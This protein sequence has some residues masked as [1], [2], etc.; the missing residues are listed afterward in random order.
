MD[1]L[2]Q[3]RVNTILQDSKGLMWFGTNGGLN[4]Y[5]GYDF[6]IFEHIAYDSTS[7]S[8]N[9]LKSIL[10]DSNGYIWI[11]TNVGLNRFD[12]YTEKFKTYF[13]DSN[14]GTRLSKITEMILDR[15]NNIWIISNNDLIIFNIGM[16]LIS[17]YNNKM[18]F[19]IVVL[20]GKESLEVGIEVLRSGALDYITKSIES[21]GKLPFI[22]DRTIAQ[23]KDI[24]ARKQLDVELK[25]SEEIFRSITNSALEGI[26]MVNSAQCYRNSFNIRFD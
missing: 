13:L 15:F 12:P 18:E 2:S 17:S 16:E 20:T 1:G 26:I 11:G 10:E 9:Y 14:V 19:P 23:W 22:I 6:K 3:S 5:D 24:S 21:L 8:N 25:E 7:I 4:R